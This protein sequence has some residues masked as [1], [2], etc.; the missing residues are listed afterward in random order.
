MRDG[1]GIHHCSG[2][3]SAALP[4]ARVF[5]AQGS[6]LYKERMAGNTEQDDR[7]AEALTLARLADVIV[8]C[9]GL[10]PSIEGEEG[11]ASNEYAAE[12]STTCIFPKVSGDWYMQCV[13]PLTR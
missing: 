11:D 8:L 3:D 5:V 7:L 2:W 13:M 9:V 4:H 10:D 1:G 12:I 6:H